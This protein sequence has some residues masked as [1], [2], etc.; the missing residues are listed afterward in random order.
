VKVTSLD[1]YNLRAPRELLKV[2]RE[3]Y[4][5]IIGLSVGDR[6]P[7][8]EFGYWLCAGDQAVL[9]LSEGGEDKMH[10]SAAATSF[11]HAAFACTGRAA[12]EQHLSEHGIDYEVARV[13]DAGPIQ[14]FLC[15]PAG[16]G[17]ELSF[18]GDEN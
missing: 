8:A 18:A 10:S 2:L 13:P 4:C 17:I 9:H 12:F 11:S 1:H 3:F 16:N 6:P 15:D 5:E 7:F 14:L